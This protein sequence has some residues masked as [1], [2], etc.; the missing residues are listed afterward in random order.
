M[1]VI[2]GLTT[3]SW[4]DSR[5]FPAVLGGIWRAEQ[6][7]QRAQSQEGHGSEQGLQ[8]LNGECQVWRWWLRVTPSG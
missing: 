1:A 5:K 4:D 7:K 8:M 2:A 3:T 6:G